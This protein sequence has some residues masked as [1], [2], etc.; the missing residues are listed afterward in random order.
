MQIHA[1]KNEDGGNGSWGKNK[2]LSSSSLCKDTE[3]IY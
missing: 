3:S 2:R 1:F